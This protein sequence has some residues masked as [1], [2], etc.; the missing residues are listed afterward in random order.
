VIDDEARLP[1]YET[2]VVRVWINRS[3]QTRQ[4][5]VGFRN[6]V[7]A[8]GNKKG[9][10]RAGVLRVFAKHLR[11]ALEKSVLRN[12]TDQEP[13]LRRAIVRSVDWFAI[14]ESF[15]DA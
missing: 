8:E 3:P 2:W 10:S 9:A 15:M 4:A 12:S 7:I 1:N 5:V 6:R 13:D 11:S 14:A